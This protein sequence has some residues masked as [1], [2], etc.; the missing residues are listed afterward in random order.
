MAVDYV[1]IFM[2]SEVAEKGSMLSIMALIVLTSFRIMPIIAL[3]PFFGARVLPHPVKVVFSLILV[4]AVMPKILM[5]STVPLAFD[6][7]LIML[8]F[9]EMFIGLIM[10]FF[11]GIPFL[12]VTS[13]GVFIDHQRGAASLMVNDPTIQNQSSPIGTIYNLVLIA[14][15]YSIDGPFFVIDAIL[16]SFQIVPPD[17]YLNPLFF[18]PQSYLKDKIFKL[19]QV[20]AVMA[21]QLSAPSLIA[22]LM[23]DTFLGVINRLAPQ[24]QIYFLGI[25]LKSWLACLMVCIGW[26]Y[27]TD[28]LKKES[29]S[30]LRDFLEMIPAFNTGNPPVIPEPIPPL[31]TVPMP[32]P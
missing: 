5:T 23:T 8:G 29:I 24:V 26:M 31:H 7:N 10:G 25:G 14:I 27:F 9:K 11:L 15:F 1:D 4:V 22:M 16:D 18:A 32:A 3:A 12:I 21:L 17:Q 30:W 19:L 6:L 13:A 20:F 28:I 2:R